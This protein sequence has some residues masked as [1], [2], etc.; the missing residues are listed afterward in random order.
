[1]VLRELNRLVE[2]KVEFAFESTLSGLLYAKK[3][4]GWKAQRYSMEIN[5]I[6]LPSPQ[7]AL[8]RI[9]ARVKQGRVACDERRHRK[10]RLVLSETMEGAA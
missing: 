3:M 7:L 5:Y 9:A 8:R 10:W 6:R 1:V 2:A 4:Q